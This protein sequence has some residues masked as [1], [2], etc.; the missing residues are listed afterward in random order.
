MLKCSFTY[1]I[2]VTVDGEFFFKK[3]LFSKIKSNNCSFKKFV[4]I[5]SQNS[6]IYS[7]MVAIV[8]LRK[9]TAY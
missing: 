3:V 2:M 4:F 6:E 8:M 7:V 1:E 9:H 5:G